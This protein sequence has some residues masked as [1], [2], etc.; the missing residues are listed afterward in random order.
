[1]YINLCWCPDV[2]LEVAISVY[3]RTDRN[4]RGV[5]YPY[6]LLPGS[7]QP[8]LLVIYNSAFLQ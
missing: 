3:V 7:L 8:L 5:L 2:F 4:S 6:L 1:M